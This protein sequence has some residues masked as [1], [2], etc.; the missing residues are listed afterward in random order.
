MVDEGHVIKSTPAWDDLHN[1]NASKES[2]IRKGCVR[3][4]TSVTPCTSRLSPP[5]LS[6][7]FSKISLPSL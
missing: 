2:Y 5:C 4:A 6:L 1:T 7:A 3:E